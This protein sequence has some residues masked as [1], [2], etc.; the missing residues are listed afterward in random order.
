MLQPRMRLT[1]HK[2]FHNVIWKSMR[3]LPAS[4]TSWMMG[5][6]ANVESGLGFLWR[7]VV[8]VHWL[9]HRMHLCNT[10]Y[11]P[12]NITGSY[13]FE[14]TRTYTYT[15]THTSSI[16]WTWVLLVF[17]VSVWIAMVIRQ[18]CR[19]T[20]CIESNNETRLC[21]GYWWII[22]SWYHVKSYTAGL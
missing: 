21:S 5:G 7:H 3:W 12:P 2:C 22:Y 17:V 6:N 9:A 19:F 20:G 18:V 1:F 14:R 13:I 11:S 10:L 15:H 4:C 16:A 8:L